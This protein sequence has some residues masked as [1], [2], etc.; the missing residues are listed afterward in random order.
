MPVV[1]EAESFAVCIDP[2]VKDVRSVV[3]AAEAES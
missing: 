3:G 1:L 2:I